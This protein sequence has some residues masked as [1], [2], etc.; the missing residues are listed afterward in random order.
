[1]FGTLSSLLNR[2]RNNGLWAELRGTGASSFGFIDH[3]GC[4]A[5]VSIDNDMLWIEFWEKSPDPDATP[6]QEANLDDELL[7]EKAIVDW[8]HN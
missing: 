4:S 7:A 2:L 8:L 1:M 5:E 3:D 6:V